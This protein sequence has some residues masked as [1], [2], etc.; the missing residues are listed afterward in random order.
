MKRKAIKTEIVINAPADKVWNILTNLSGYSDWNPFIVESHGAIQTKSRIR[1]VMKNGDKTITFK[2]V[3]QRVEPPFYFDWV[4]RLF[5][6]GI[7]DGH[8]YFQIEPITD[9]QVKLIHGEHF[10]GI[11]AGPI[12][13]KIGSETAQNFI[14]MNQALREEAEK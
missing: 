14:R 10:S 5:V 1:N 12:L 13:K 7:F 2:P 4:G 9:N 3:I 6:P 11:L 8:H